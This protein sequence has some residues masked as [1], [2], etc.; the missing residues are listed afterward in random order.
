MILHGFRSLNL[1]VRL[2]SQIDSKF[3]FTGY[4]FL[5]DFLCAVSCVLLYDFFISKELP[6]FCERAVILFALFVMYRLD[7][8]QSLVA[9]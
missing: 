4:C 3:S 2:Y 8:D 9:E 7:C 1:K 6:G 5:L